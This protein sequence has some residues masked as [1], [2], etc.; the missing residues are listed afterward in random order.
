MSLVGEQVLLRVYLQSADRT[1]HTPTYERVVKAA[2][3]RGSPAP[4]FYAESWV[5]D[6]TDSSNARLGPS[7]STFR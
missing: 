3:K 4:L 7:S 1:P 6:R 2:R 5:W